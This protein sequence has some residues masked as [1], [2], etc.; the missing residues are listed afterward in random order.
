MANGFFKNIARVSGNNM[1]NAVVRFATALL[2]ARLL[3]PAGKGIYASLLVVPAMILSISELGIRRSTIVHLGEQKYKPNDIIAVLSFFFLFTSIVGTVITFFVYRSYDSGELSTLIIFLALAS[4]PIRLIGKFSNSVFVATEQYKKFTLLRSIPVFLNMLFVVVFVFLARWSI[5]GALLA[6]VLSNLIS[7]LYSYRMLAKH[8]TVSIK[9]NLEIIKSLLSLG[10]VY[11]IALFLARLNFKIDILLLKVLS[12]SEQ[13]G[14]YSLGAGFAEKFQTPF[15]IGAVILSSGA[16][17]KNQD[18][19]NK[20]V[21]KLFRVSLLY[22]IFISVAIYFLSPY[23]MPLL[24][25]EA[26]IPSI[27]IVQNI[28]PAIVWLILLKLLGNRIASLKKTAYMIWIHVPA[29]IVNIALNYLLIPQYQAMGAVIATN[30]SYFLSFMGILFLYGKVTKS[31]VIDLVRFKKEDFYFLR[32]LKLA[33][34]RKRQ[35]DDNSDA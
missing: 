13:V 10:I 6:L 24:Y 25:G 27:A 20:D 18:Q 11:A 29:L 4:I 3:G 21:A 26:Y 8:Y 30:V 12:S 1:L 2:V 23:V 7:G 31:S 14:F 28:L 19:V 16:N 15:A 9:F 32:Y 33:K 35:K 34:M 22:T 17:S 5:T